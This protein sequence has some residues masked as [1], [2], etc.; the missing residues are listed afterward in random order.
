MPKERR[1]KPE[2][3]KWHV[4]NHRSI[5]KFVI[6][7]KADANEAIK[8]Y[9]KPFNISQSRVYLMSQASSRQELIERDKLVVELA[10]E[11]GFNFSPRLQIYIWDQKTGI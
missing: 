3:V 6:E 11:Y 1:Y 9:I 4:T 8:E 2:V 10:K 5:F 7:N